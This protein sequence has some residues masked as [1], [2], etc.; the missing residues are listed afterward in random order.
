MPIQESFTHFLLIWVALDHL[1]YESGASSAGV[2]LDSVI[3]FVLCFVPL[4][5]I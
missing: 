4:N 1:K 2:F 3:L 5:F